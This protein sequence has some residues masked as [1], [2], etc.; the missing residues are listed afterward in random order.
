MRKLSKK[1]LREIYLE[2]ALFQLP[3]SERIEFHG[4]INNILNFEINEL[5]SLERLSEY[6]NRSDELAEY[7]QNKIIDHSKLIMAKLGG[8]TMD[9]FEQQIAEMEAKEK[10]FDATKTRN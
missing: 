5:E 3:L 9:Q 6:T 7:V 2:R 4:L 10:Q 8:L 1:I